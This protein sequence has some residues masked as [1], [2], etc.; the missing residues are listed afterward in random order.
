[1]PINVRATL[2]PYEGPACPRCNAR[3]TKDWIVSGTVTCPDCNKDFNAVA[4][5]P[6]PEKTVITEVAAAG[7]ELANACA[8]HAR[9]AAVTNCQRCG[10]FI[11]ALCEMDVGSGPFCPA[12]FDRL[13][14]E[15][16][17]RGAEQR[18]RDYR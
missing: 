17:L 10:L 16:T 4:F 9:N 5:T 8:N 2:T 6:P 13:R 7:P 12:C 3:L 14:T 15:G 1:M 18:T 11:C